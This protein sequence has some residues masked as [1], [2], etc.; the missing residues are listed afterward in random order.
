VRWEKVLPSSDIPHGRPIAAFLGT[1]KILIARLES[2]A[3]AA[4]HPLCPH[5]GAD[6]TE[7]TVYMGAVDC[8]R[9]HYLYDLTTGENR[10]P[11][12]VYPADLACAL[13]PLR[14]YPAREAAGWVEIALPE[15]D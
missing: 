12:E 5:E 9:H 8:P 11:K 3:V 4:A 15:R 2:G 13:K 14:L 6:L 7:G 10:Y 1:R